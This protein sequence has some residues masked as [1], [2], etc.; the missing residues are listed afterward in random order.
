MRVC[1]WA[2]AGA[3]KSATAEGLSNH[4]KKN[5]HNVELVREFI[6]EWAYLKRVP[7]S[8]E[9]GYITMS[10]LHQEDFVLNRGVEHIVTD[11]PVLM[12][13]AYC[14]KYDF[15]GTDELLSLAMKFEKK[16]PS[17]NIFLSR[18][19]IE[20]KQNGRYEDLA[21]AVEMDD[22]LMRFMDSNDIPYWIIP[23]IDDKRL[24]QV[25]EDH[26]NGVRYTRRIGSGCP[27]PVPDQGDGREAEKGNLDGLSPGGD[28]LWQS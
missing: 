11:S 13:V 7:V 4:L 22:F 16:Y 9:P 3:G 14:K 24:Y 21:K 23:T 19:G 5:K 26:L 6:K 17:L 10:Q 12:S 28:P 20:Y 2:G 8:F 1:L 18:D 15:E 25:V 27:P